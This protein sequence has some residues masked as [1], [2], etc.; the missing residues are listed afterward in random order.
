MPI[1]KNPL[2]VRSAH[3][4]DLP[5][6]GALMRPFVARG[7][8]LARSTEE[9]S[10]LVHHG[11]VA[12]AEGRVVGFAALEVY[13]R[14][15]AEIQCLSFD[16]EVGAEEVARHVVLPC[17]ERAREQEVLEVMAV[18]PA[19]LEPVLETCG[20]HFSLP[21][22]KRAM[23]IRPDQAGSIHGAETTSGPFAGAVIRSATA[24]DLAPAAEFLSPFVAR[25]ELLQRNTEELADLLRHAFLAEAGG[26]AVGFAALEIYSRKLA[27]IQCLSVERAYRRHGI[28]RQLV[29]LCVQRAREH[30]VAE[31]MAISLRDEFFLEC[32][33]GYCLA[34]PR[35]AMFLRTREQ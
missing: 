6:V 29:T 27:E 30:H 35:M 10:D 9:L 17:A 20:F 21:N 31:T 28:G 23:F 14:K 1:S 8:L 16:P 18:V 26:R 12:E 13:S 32:G 34:G 2:T 22:Q 7:D 25:G 19:A 15:L 3:H 5:S 4:R 24:L 11:F 33:F